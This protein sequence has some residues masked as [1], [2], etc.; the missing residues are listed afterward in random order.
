MSN[1]NTTNEQTNARESNS[2]RTQAANYR[3]KLSFYHANGKG[4]GS[5]ARFEV[6]PATGDRDGSVF[7]TLAQQKSVA[8]GSNDQGNRQHATF[9]WMNRVTVKLN[10]SDLCQMLP[11]FKGLAV[12][13]NEGKG[14]YH[15]SRS[16]TTII[17]LTHQMEPYPGY[18]LD[19]SRRNKSG[20]DPA[21]RIR[22]LFNAA[23]A[24]GLSIVLEQAL[25]LLAFGIPREYRPNTETAPTESEPV[26]RES[27]GDDPTGF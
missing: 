17:N 5:V 27:D 20:G 9:D 4:T 10:F 8:S 7:L 1:N 18:A 13:V 16:T 21:P 24:Y 19:V 6:V 2:D 22:I 14:L 3:P 23:E 11:V 26:S 25:G 12:N 15:D